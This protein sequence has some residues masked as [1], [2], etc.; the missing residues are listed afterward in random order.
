MKKYPALIILILLILLT[1]CQTGKKA[2][3][4]SPDEQLLI[5]AGLRSSIQQAILDTESELFTK[6]P[7][8]SDVP[9]YGAYTSSLPGFRSLMDAY[10][11]EVNSAV[12][13]ALVS[14]SD[15]LISYMSQYTF[16]DVR[17]VLESGY[18]SVSQILRDECADEVAG[19]FAQALK[20]DR[21]KVM[22]AYDAAFAESE[23]WRKNLA[24][25]A[26]V[27]Q[28]ILLDPV[29]PLDEH[30]L[31]VLAMEVYF[32]GLSENEVRIRARGDANGK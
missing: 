2:E 7:L 31:A 13:S 30:A 6:Q 5:A 28:E 25:L 15:Y 4:Y 18:S 29:M 1:S 24:N 21:D 19:I 14:V 32:N 9:E 3:G 16:T 20:D 8:L 11:A 12:R 10:L 26:L 22:N 17:K 23:V 27:G